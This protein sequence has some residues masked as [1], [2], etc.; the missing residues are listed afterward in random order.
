MEI[1]YQKHDQ[2]KK[3]AKDFWL[4]VATD[5]NGGLSASKIAKRYTNPR[6]GKPYTRE[7]VYFILKRIKNTPIGDL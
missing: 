1:K 5:Y 2:R 4:R 6:T 7:H 3:Q